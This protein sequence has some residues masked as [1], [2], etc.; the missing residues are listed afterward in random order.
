[1]KDSLVIYFQNKIIRYREV[2]NYLTK[3]NIC[4][5]T[6][7]IICLFSILIKY[8][9]EY[10]QLK[11]WNPINYRYIIMKDNSFIIRILIT[12]RQSQFNILINIK[13]L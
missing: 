5:P 3:P 1:M 9:K 4:L 10:Q 11:Y 6:E 8:Y 13:Q 7:M 2:I 12:I